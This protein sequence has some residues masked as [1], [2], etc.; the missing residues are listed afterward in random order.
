MAPI[1][2]LRRVGVGLSGSADDEPGVKYADLFIDDVRKL[3]A[4][5]ADD[6]FAVQNLLTKMREAGYSEEDIRM[7]RTPFDVMVDEQP[8]FALE[9]EG[10]DR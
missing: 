5:G 9:D 10:E 4:S 6:S 8:D 2:V 7:A 3:S 1:K